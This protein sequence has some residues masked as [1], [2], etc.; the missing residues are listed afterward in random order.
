MSESSQLF[1]EFIMRRCEEITQED[2][3]Y[4]EI[5][6][7]ITHLEE[8]IKEQIKKTAPKE[9]LLNLQEY[10]NLV[11]KLEGYTQELFYKKGI[12]DLLLF[13]S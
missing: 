13:N 7:C 12:K 10:S 2:G 6:A 9:V 5:C 3:K 11:L 1:E 4:Q 8:Q